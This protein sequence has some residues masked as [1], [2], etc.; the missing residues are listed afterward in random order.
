M[1][2]D[3]SSYSRVSYA[4]ELY[5]QTDGAIE[6]MTMAV[7]AGGPA[8]ENTEW[9]RAQL[10]TLYFNKG[11]LAGA[12]QQYLTSLDNVQDFVPALAG[13]GRVRV[14]QGKVEEGIGLLKQAIARMPLPEYVIALGEIEEANGRGAEA[15][16]QYELVRAMEQL[17]KSNGVDTDLELALFDADHGSDPQATLALAQAAYER[18][19][20]VKGADTL[21][22]ALFKAGRL[23]EARKRATE[24]LHLGTKDA[25]MFYHAG[26]IAKAQGD[27]TA[28]RD[29]LQRSLATNPYFSPLFVP[30][31]QA[32]LKDLAG[33]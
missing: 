21:A 11:D 30:Q 7:R 13:L 2:P 8:A 3:L 27:K 18:R 4:R 26:M 9:T 24:A 22:W 12:E 1:R 20:S 31:A 25:L 19:P 14:A 10:G 33:A 29:Y 28:A 23:D 32:A 15:A 6:A 16:K 5:G 17:F